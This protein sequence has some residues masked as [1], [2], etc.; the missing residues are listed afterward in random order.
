MK[1]IAVIGAGLS[2]LVF[3]D[4]LKDLVE[5]TIFEK[6]RGVGGRISTRR[7][8]SYEFDHGAQYFTVRTKEFQNFIEPLMHYKIIDRWNARYV[9]F[10]GNKI[11]ERKDWK[12][13]EPRYVGITGMNK[14]AKYLSAGIDVKLNT[15]ITS[16][17]HSIKW[18]LTDETGN[19]YGDFD[20][21]I[22]TAPSPQSCDILPKDFKYYQEIKSL[23]MSPC[24]ALMLGFSS[25]LNLDFDAAHVTNSDLSWIAIN[26]AKPGRSSNFTLMA[27]SSEDYAEKY[28]DDDKGFVMDHL[29]SEASKIIGYDISRADYKNIHAWRYANNYNNYQINQKHDVFLDANTKLAVCGDWCVGGRVE[30]AFESAYNLANKMKEVI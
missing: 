9:K 4:L 2:G 16:I 11:I 26:N 22:S 24:I 21:I 12:D 18:H 10:D 1:K 13:H 5:I 8:G 28:I 7:S 6:S 20:W 3:A 19:T 25:H 15:R 23:K 30:G 14:I 17:E 29:I 27:H